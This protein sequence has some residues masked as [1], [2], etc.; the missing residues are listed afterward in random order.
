MNPTQI[1]DSINAGTYAKNSSYPMPFSKGAYLEFVSEWKKSYAALTAAIRA[2]K[3]LHRERQ[4]SLAG[5]SRLT[6]EQLAELEKQAK[7]ELPKNLGFVTIVPTSWW[8]SDHL[9]TYVEFLL[10]LRKQMKIEANKSYH[11]THS[12]SGQPDENALSQSNT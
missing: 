7:F 12:T 8:K 10:V 9:W 4:R 5:K 2:R 3:A 11:A 1:I 6:T